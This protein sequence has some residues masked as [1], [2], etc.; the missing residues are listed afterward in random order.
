MGPTVRPPAAAALRA[1]LG[2]TPLMTAMGRA[3]VA[4]RSVR[5]VAS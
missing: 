2:A 1:T 4:P 5:A 3:P